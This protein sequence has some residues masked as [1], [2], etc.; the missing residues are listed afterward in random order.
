MADR[1]RFST[2]DNQM[3]RVSEIIGDGIIDGWEIVPQTFPNVV[4]T[5]GGGLIDGYYVNTFDDQ[6]FTLSDNGIFYLYSQRRVGIIGSEG[7]KSDIA[8]V[9]YIDSG[10]PSNPT[11][12]TIAS[13]IPSS[14]RYKFTIPLQ[15]TGIS[16]IDFSHYQ[17]QRNKDGGDYEIV[18]T[19]S[20]TY[21]EDEIDENAIYNYRVYAIDQS[22]N[23]SSGYTG[24]MISVPLSDSLPPNP[25][26][27]EMY[28]SEAAI[29]VLWKRHPAGDF[30]IIDHWLITY[31][32]LDTDY[33]PVASTSL[34]FIV[35]KVLYYNR[36]DDLTVGKTYQVTLQAVDSQGRESTGVVRNIIPQPSPAPRDPEGVAYTFDVGEFGVK[37]D[38][39]WTSGDTPYDPAISYRY[40]IYP[41]IG[42]L[43]EAQSI[44]IPPGLTEEQISLYTFNGSEYFSIPENTLITFRITALDVNGFESAGTYVRFVTAQFSLPLS[45]GNVQTDFDLDTS[46]LVVTWT[47]QADTDDVNVRIV[48]EEITEDAYDAP[49]EV[50]NENI[51]RSERYV[52]EDAETDKKYTVYLT[53]INSDDV[54]GNPSV[55]VELSLG[56]GNLPLPD[57]PN[58]IESKAGDKQILLT[59]D[60]SDTAY[61]N[62][63]NL[64]RKEGDVTF[65]SEDWTLLDT[66]QESVTRFTDYGLENDQPYSY[67]ITATDIYG[68]E[69]D[70][71][72]E[73]AVNLN[74]TTAVPRAEGALTE[75]TG[76]TVTIIGDD[77]EI[78]WDALLEEFDSYTIYRTID[79][80]HSWEVIAH[81]DKDTFTYMDANIPLI[82]GT[83]FHYIVDK[84]INDADI[85]VQSS[86]I[87]PPNSV[88]IG[89][90]TLSSGAFGIPDI[91]CR[92]DIADM[93]D[94]LA[95][96]TFS[97]I[98]DHKHKGLRPLDPDRIDLNA[99]LIITD[100]FTVD[101]RIWFTR[102][103]ILGGTYIVKV[104]GRF[105]RVFFE[106]DEVTGRIIFSEA[107]NTSST[108][109]MRILGIEEVQNVLDEFRFDNIHAK[110]VQFGELNF[111]QL[112]ELNH[113]GRIRELVFPK[114]YL[115]ERYNNHNFIVPQGNND[116]TKTF[117]D[118]T[119]FYATIDSDGRI[120]EIIDFDTYDDGLV[121]GFQ[122]PSYSSD[123]ILNLKQS[124]SANTNIENG[125]NV[126]NNYTF[127]SSTLLC[128][129]SS[130]ATTLKAY[131]WSTDTFHTIRDMTSDLAS[132][133]SNRLIN[134]DSTRKK[135]YIGGDVSGGVGDV[136]SV[137]PA[138]GRVLYTTQVS[139]ILGTDMN[140]VVYN[141]DDD[142]FYI[143]DQFN[144]IRYFSEATSWVATSLGNPLFINISPSYVDSSQTIDNLASSTDINP[145]L[146]YG[147]ASPN[148][149]IRMRISLT[150]AHTFDSI[151][152]PISYAIRAS[153]YDHDTPGLLISTF[154]VDLVRLTN[155]SD[156][157]FSGTCTET[158]LTTPS[159]SITGMLQISGSWWL[160][161]PDTLKVGHFG[162]LSSNSYLRFSID[163]PSE[164]TIS[165][166]TL[167]LTGYGSIGSF[168]VRVSVLDPSEYADS[169]EASDD[170]LATI[171]NL[172]SM[173]ITPA[174]VG[175]GDQIQI[176]VHSLME[177]FIASDAYYPGRH[178][179][180]KFEALSPSPVNYRE[181]YGYGTSS[182]PGLDISYV[183]DT[184]EVSSNPGGFQSEKAYRL[185]WEFE[186]SK[187]TR[188]VRISTR[189]TALKP[190]PVIDLV[191]RL[192]FR[193]KLNTGS[194]YMGF[195][196]REITQTGLE[197]GENGGI[198]GPIEWVN[199]DEI[200]TDDAGNVTPK[201]S[202]LVT[203]SDEWQ[204]IDIDL[205]KA[206]TISLLDGNGILGRGLGVLEHIAFTINPDNP[207]DRKSVV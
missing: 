126:A 93:A 178:V 158:I 180:F 18:D 104:D 130:A 101:G 92:R 110:Q 32:E 183:V 162:G 205:Q 86:D 161:N 197:T 166:S 194:V 38:M 22:G 8:S 96:Y 108:I 76:V 98:L 165:T 122:A 173:I 179:I 69:S 80:L 125:D 207:P 140:R 195:G 141:R 147:T 133:L 35:N 164:H 9:T 68:R 124:T 58:N 172:A 53:P 33:S 16:D 88:C 15:W 36:I 12:L 3:Y 143:I 29:N 120:K 50:I 129:T 4:V 11:G 94:P 159:E 206:S 19:I 41:R 64:Y 89:E 181:Y 79:N 65:N 157:G 175:D 151:C 105:P 203:A 21:Y 44:D 1:R 187:E 70:N 150:G 144:E 43:E 116:S 167:N 131:N 14:T 73:G 163:V 202:T 123:T 115:L 148:S 186:D 199:V 60:R 84:T 136:H 201:G 82:D 26:E 45:L 109:E 160:G 47:N 13:P 168:S 189:E 5:A 192:R 37:V 177:A 59:W 156:P 139:S 25:I 71:L 17:I 10:P 51:G 31:I 169:I 72:G 77:I 30:S 112:P 2:I 100:W 174:A 155:F 95:E 111:E 119:T 20:S 23:K 204:E 52:Y 34:S 191:K 6:A 62:Y 75:P 57:P 113:E 67:F 99:E 27:V 200:L 61:T 85:V 39:S 63:Y 170:A 48:E 102:E 190:N 117:G 134:L 198:V 106:V 56:S 54:E 188:W 153:A 145:G 196:I 154:G 193:I 46:N 176:K 137:D 132:S 40:K 49:V 28:Q 24:G 103:N 171:S 42:D 185:Q 90:I 128:Y 138:T 74:F 142:L 152:M 107:I 135:M 97:F 83:V 7:P 118:G 66:I 184:A 91:T 87:T 114:R 55:S 78:T 149:L 81:V 121:V 146:F 127:A 182:A